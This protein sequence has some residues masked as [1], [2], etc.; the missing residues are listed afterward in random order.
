VV[1]FCFFCRDGVIE[2]VSIATGTDKT[3][4]QNFREI[5]L[6]FLGQISQATDRAMFYFS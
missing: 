4:E 5:P 1:I 6:I 3:L 2:V